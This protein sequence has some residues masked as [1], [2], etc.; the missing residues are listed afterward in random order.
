[1][2]EK[3]F[4]FAFVTLLVAA[5]SAFFV[6][7]IRS[8]LLTILLAGIF[9]GLVQPLYRRLLHACRDRKTPAAVLTLVLLLLAVIGPLVAFLGV[10]TSQALQIAD[11]VGPWIEGQIH[12]TDNITRLM[13]RFPVLGR[14]EPYRTDI[15]SKLGQAVGA[16]GNFIVAG[17][18][19]TTRGTLQFFFHFFILLFT[20]FFFLKDGG[21]ILKKILSYVPLAD[22]DKTMIVGKFASV[23]RAM[24]KGTL[25]IGIVQGGLAGFAFAIAGIHGAVFWGTV[26]TV[27]SIIPGVGTAFVWVPAV[28]YLLAVGRVAAGIALAIFCGIVV[29]SADNL[30]RPRLVGRDAK[31]HELLI[32]FGTLG[33]MLLFGVVGFIIGPVV[34]AL[35]VTIWDIYGAV[36]RDTV[37]KPRPVDGGPSNPGA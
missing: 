30:L 32:L 5:I 8:F 9:A 26:M 4:R 25:V 11:T 10:L 2:D 31:M 37:A 19:A 15:I 24:L 17:L 29:G 3:K 1:V 28:V 27:L 21:A 6:A 18:S 23:S 22:D 16:I 34:A 20:M 12:E 7:M 36:I 33:G 13:E 14:L 35:F